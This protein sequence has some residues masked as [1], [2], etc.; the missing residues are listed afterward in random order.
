MDSRFSLNE[1]FAASR[2]EYEF[3][4]DDASSVFGGRSSVV[5]GVEES[6]AEVGVQ[7]DEALAPGDEGDSVG[8]EM[9]DDEADFY[10]VLCVDREAPKEEVRAA[11]FRWFELL[12]A[13]SHDDDLARAYFS[14]VQ[15]AFETLVDCRRREEYDVSMGRTGPTRKDGMEVSSDM[16]IRVDASGRKG[17]RPVD[18]VLGHSVSMG[19]PGLG[20][21][22][23][24]KI[25]RIHG[26]L[27]RAKQDGERDTPEKKAEAGSGTA[28]IPAPTMTV[29]GYTYGLTEALPASVPGRY[30]PLLYTLPRHKTELLG[31]LSPLAT[32]SLRQDLLAKDPSDATP[33]ASAVEIESSLVPPASLTT[34]LSHTTAARGT[35]TS[36]AIGVTADRLQPNHPQLALAASRVLGS[37]VAFARADSGHWRL[38]ADETCRY[39]GEFSRLS[40]GMLNG[41][42]GPKAASFEVGFTQGMPGKTVFRHNAMGVLRGERA[43]LEPILSA[44]TVSV[45]GTAEALA[46]SLRYA[47]DISRTKLEVELSTT[48]RANHHV[49]IRNLFPLGTSPSALGLELSLSPQALHLSFSF[50][51]LNQRFSLPVYMLPLP[52]TLFLAAAIPFILSAGMAF[53]R[54]KKPAEPR[55]KKSDKRREADSLTFLLHRSIEQQQSTAKGDLKVLSAKYGAPEDGWAGE[56]VADVTVA[57]SALV[58][59]GRVEIPA[60]LRTSHLPGFW[61]PAPGRKKVIR[62][63]F[64]AGGREGI[65]EGTEGDG[66]RIP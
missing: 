19:L 53:L 15:E 18:F 55:R 22:V 45:G 63:R 36:L 51:H 65:V 48:S 10:E 59:D 14:R 17:A 5:R 34:R 3:G 52:R 20:A 6:V 54:R 46:S 56:D 40:G 35:P 11:Y 29:S 31:N 64:R 39:F 4:D 38:R 12:H 21:V 32:I 27:S 25:R 62:V 47:M 61:D 60:G 26:F 24:E 23:K 57:L 7:D 50:S 42:F 13:P 58:R 2:T 30:H 1:H 43:V 28:A 16:G 37:G 41:K 49:A 33:R 9:S 66:L 44:W 8:D